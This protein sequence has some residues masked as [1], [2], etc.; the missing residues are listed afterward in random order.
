MR[1]SDRAGIG[2]LTVGILMLVFF[3]PTIFVVGAFTAMLWENPALAVVF[4]GMFGY[5]IWWSVQKRRKAK[6]NV[7]SQV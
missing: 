2:L 4:A 3:V 5:C 7:T 1:N 6:Q